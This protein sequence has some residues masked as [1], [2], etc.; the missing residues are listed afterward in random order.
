MLCHACGYKLAKDGIDTRP[1]QTSLG[2]RNIR[3]TQN[4]TNVSS[5]RFR[6]FWKD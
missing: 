2:H 1:L 5:S 3:H 6:D 4:Y